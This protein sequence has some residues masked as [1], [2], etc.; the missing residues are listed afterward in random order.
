MSVRPEH[1]G[2]NSASQDAGMAW[3][4]KRSN[5]LTLGQPKSNQQ[6]ISVYW[7]LNVCKGVA[8]KLWVEELTPPQTRSVWSPP[9]KL[10][11]E[12]GK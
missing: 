12:L 1:W 9:R 2:R 3:G 6:V 7:G 11:D 5:P 4:P 10:R 8:G